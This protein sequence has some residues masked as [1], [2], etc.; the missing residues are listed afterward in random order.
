[1]VIDGTLGVVPV[2]TRDVYEIAATEEDGTQPEDYAVYLKTLNGYHKAAMRD[3]PADYL[4]RLAKLVA[5]AE[6]VLPSLRSYAAL[7]QDEFTERYADWGMQVRILGEYFIAVRSV[8]DAMKWLAAREGLA[9]RPR[10]H[11]YAHALLLL[12]NAGVLPAEH[13]PDLVRMIQARN[14]FTHHMD[15]PTAAEMRGYLLDSVGAIPSLISFLRE[16]YLGG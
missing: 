9:R 11:S 2:E 5:E 10:S 12:C 6:R 16:R 7:S 4:A 15:N 13:L 1:M 3:T 14:A 8:V